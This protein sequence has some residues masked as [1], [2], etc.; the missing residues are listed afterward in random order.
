MDCLQ[1]LR[2]EIRYDYA[3][4]IMQLTWLAQ[5]DETEEAAEFIFVEKKQGLL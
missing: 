2:M 1:Y 4:I 3:A 5:W